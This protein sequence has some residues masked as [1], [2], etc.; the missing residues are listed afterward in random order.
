MTELKETLKRAAWRGADAFLA[1][2]VFDNV[3]GLGLPELKVAAAAAASAAIKPVV[4]Y[5]SKKAGTA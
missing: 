4:A 2:F 5:V 1:A 3:F